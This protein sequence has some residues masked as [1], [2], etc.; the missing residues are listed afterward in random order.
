MVPDTVR[1][2]NHVCTQAKYGWCLKHTMAKSF[3]S[4]AVW[5][6]ILTSFFLLD[7]YGEANHQ[8]T[9]VIAS[10]KEQSS[11]SLTPSPNLFPQAQISPSKPLLTAM[12]PDSPGIC[13]P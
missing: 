4:L 7:I 9:L 1:P 2:C 13:S 6:M 10:N 12:L 8:M 3:P 11:A 5:M